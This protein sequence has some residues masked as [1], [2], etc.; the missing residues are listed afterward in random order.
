MRPSGIARGR[1]ALSLCVVELQ[2]P[3]LLGLVKLAQVVIAE[4]DPALA[5]LSDPL[6]YRWRHNVAAHHTTFCTDTGPGHTGGV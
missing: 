5:E 3:A 6:L 1:M 4:R 2:H